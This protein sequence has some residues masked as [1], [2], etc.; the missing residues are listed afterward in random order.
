M[1]RFGYFLRNF[2]AMLVSIIIIVF[3]VSLVIVAANFVWNSINSIFGIIYFK[4]MICFCI[5]LS[6]VYAMYMDAEKWE[7]YNKLKK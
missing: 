4:F 7:R 6:F 3:V 1:K 2:F 5:A